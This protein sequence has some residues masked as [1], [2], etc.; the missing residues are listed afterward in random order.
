MSVGGGHY[1]IDQV[2]RLARAGRIVATKRVTQW[3]SNH[4]YDVRE[5]LVEVLSSL[6]AH[7]RFTG[8]CVLKN[9]ETADEYLVLLPE[10][11]W[12]LKF[13]VDEDQLV[14]DVW[15]CCWD[16]AVH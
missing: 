7:G 12:Y 14:V 10:D 16:G 1:E 4:E 6:E 3:L 9:D 2:E 15:S 13:W 8:S 11:D 5:T